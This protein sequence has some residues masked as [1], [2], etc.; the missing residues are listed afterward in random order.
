MEITILVHLPELEARG[1]VSLAALQEACHRIV[2][3]NSPALVQS[4]S[5]PG[6]SP[7]YTCEYWD[8]TLESLSGKKPSLVLYSTDLG[9]GIFQP[10]LETCEKVGHFL[11][12]AD[13][14]YLTTG[15]ALRGE[16]L[17]RSL[18]QWYKRRSGSV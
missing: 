16:A 13:T 2:A 9:V 3:R 4:L 11:F 7:A 18:A 5:G 15:K 6:I 17:V 8:G 12:F 1:H 14:H 10:L